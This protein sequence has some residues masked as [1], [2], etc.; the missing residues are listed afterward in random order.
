MAAVTSHR[1]GLVVGSLL[2]GWHCLW[3]ILVALGWAQ[4][5]INFVFWV[6]FIKPVYTVGPFHAGIA[7]LLIVVT[8]T[9]GY[10]IGSIL[11]V[12]WNWIHQ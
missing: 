10:V 4:P 3:A 6:H 8:A 11:G 1:V 7:L 5:F 12:L 2:G 9:V